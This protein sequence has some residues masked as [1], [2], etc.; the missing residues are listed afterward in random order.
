MTSRPLFRVLSLFVLA[1]VVTVAGCT[2]P[3]RRTV[4]ASQPDAYTVDAGQPDAFMCAATLTLCDDG[5]VDTTSEPDHCGGCDMPCEAT[6]MCVDSAC[7]PTCTPTEIL[8]EAACVDPQTD[9]AHCGASGDCTGSNA[10]T[11]CAAAESCVAGVC[12]LHPSCSAILAAGLSTGDGV[13]SVDPDG[14]DP[15]APFD[16]YCD[17]TTAGGGWTLTYKVRNDVDRNTNPWWNMVMPGSGTAFPSTLDVPAATT[18]GATSAARGSFTTLSGAT[19]WRAQTRRGAEVLFDVRSMYAGANGQALRC[20]ATGLCATATQS[21]SPAVTDATVIATSTGL[22]APDATGY[23]CDI[24]WTD[25]DFCV[26]WSEVSPDGSEGPDSQRYVGDS[27]IA[28][29]DT[30]TLYWVR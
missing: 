18:E 2:T 1:L 24:G 14:T 16:V 21:C 22:F 30:Y 27:E 17:M 5:C 6:E 26:D 9:R 13:Y 15:G 12:T 25:C 10:G 28:L 8:C 11:A 7:V 29:T 19:E 4:D 23:L 20:F 3:M